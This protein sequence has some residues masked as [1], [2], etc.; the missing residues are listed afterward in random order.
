VVRER[1][2]CSSPGT[3]EDT[4]AEP[5]WIGSDVSMSNDERAG[6]DVVFGALAEGGCRGPAMEDVSTGLEAFP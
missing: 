3:A 5:P 4:A 6:S 2:D 1:D